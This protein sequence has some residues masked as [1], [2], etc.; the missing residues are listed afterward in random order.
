M[1]SF[2]EATAAGFTSLDTIVL[3]N[4]HLQCVH[5]FVLL[6][7]ISLVNNI[8]SDIFAGLIIF[9]VTFFG[10]VGCVLGGGGVVVV[11][12]ELVVLLIIII[13]EFC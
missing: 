13:I 3:L 11:L 2:R 1:S 7:N 6:L 12:I 10:G 5:L 4:V 8:N 9:L